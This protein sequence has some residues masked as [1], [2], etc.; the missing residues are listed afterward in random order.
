MD[1]FVAEVVMAACK[2]PCSICRRW[3][4][5][6]PRAGKRQKVCGRDECQRERH[7][8][9]CKAWHERE[10]DAVREERL[11]KKLKEA[12]GGGEVGAVVSSEA[13]RDAVPLE[14]R[15]FIGVIAGLLRLSMRDA[16]EREVAKITLESGRHPLRTRRDGIDFRMGPP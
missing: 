8:R 15:V 16:V 4:M 12:G 13:A 10:R 9:A 5:P 6:H 14:V 2:R 3:F 1:A 7:R 11:E